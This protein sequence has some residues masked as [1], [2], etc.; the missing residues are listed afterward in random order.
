M[1][2]TVLIFAALL[3]LGAGATQYSKLKLVRALKSAGRWGDFK[4]FV[5]QAGLTDEWESAAY[6]TDDY[7]DFALV[8]NRL[9][10]AGF[11]TAAEV[12]AL[13]AVSVD[14]AADALISQV[15][16]RDMATSSGRTRWHGRAAQ[17]VTD[18][19]TLEKTTIYEDGYRHVEKFTPPRVPTMEERLAAAERAKRREEAAR[20]RKAARIAELTTN[21]AFHVEKTMAARRWP[22][23]LARLYLQH[24]LNT[25]I[26]TNTVT[27]T[28]EPQK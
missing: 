27:V 6:L 20:R 11:A 4:T 13:L 5:S 14:N 8:T 3:A 25:L 1:K 16:T 24:E 22:E 21:L 2:K 23:D 15:Y 18:T 26:G 12:E 7:P 10:A 28:I 17:V 9:I 19:N